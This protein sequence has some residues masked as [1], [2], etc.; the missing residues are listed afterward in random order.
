MTDQEHRPIDV[1][2]QLNAMAKQ[3][4]DVRQDVKTL[5]ALATD[6]DPNSEQSAAAERALMARNAR[7]ANGQACPQCND[8]GLVYDVLGAIPCPVC[9]SSS[10]PVDR[11]IRVV[12]SDR[13]EP[14]DREGER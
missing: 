3:L 12:E 5:L 10:A 2:G 4:N 6:N 14:V 8:I 9:S 13:S 1:R 11:C 7:R